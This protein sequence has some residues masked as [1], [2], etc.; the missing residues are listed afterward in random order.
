MCR[1][2]KTLQGSRIQCLLL[3]R[4]EG[5]KVAPGIATKN[6]YCATKKL[7]YYGVKLHTITS[8]QKGTLPIPICIGI[9]DA[10]MHDRKAFEQILPA[11]P[12]NMLECY[13][14]KAYQVEANPVLL[15]GQVTLLT[16]VKKEKGQVFLDAA[17]LWLSTAIS[18][19]RQPIES[20]FNWIN[21]KQA[22]KSLAK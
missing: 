13:A 20:F 21:E 5:A 9:T 22:F 7:H 11:L 16:P 8:Q 14:D 2:K 18:Q 12:S 4:N 10:G 6:G 19:V 1:I 15:Q 3:W 17:D